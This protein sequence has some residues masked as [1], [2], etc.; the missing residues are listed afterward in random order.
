MR[1]SLAVCKSCA[2]MPY[3]LCASCVTNSTTI[4]DLSGELQRLRLMLRSVRM[5]L[6]IEERTR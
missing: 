6:E 4:N 5:T 1:R 2:K 3:K